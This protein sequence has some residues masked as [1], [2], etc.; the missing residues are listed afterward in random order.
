MIFYIKFHMRYTHKSLKYLTLGLECS[1]HVKDTYEIT[2][3][4]FT[5]YSNHVCTEF[6]R[7]LRGR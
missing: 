5:K 3:I 1:I 7:T 6:L 4:K 2:I